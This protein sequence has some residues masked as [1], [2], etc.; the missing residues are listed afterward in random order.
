MELEMPFT[1]FPQ[2]FAA[3]LSVRGMPLLQAQPGQIFWVNN[4][5]VLNPQQKAGSNGNRGTFLDPFSTLTFALTQCV[6]G[7]GDIVMVGAGHYETI[8]DATTLVMAT[9]GV[10]VIGVGSGSSRPTFVFTTATTANVTVLAAN[11]SI[12]N[13]LFMCNFAA[14]ASVF[15]VVSASV[16]AVIAATTMTVAT[17][18][19]GTLYPG[20]SV[21]GTGIIPGTIILSQVSGTTGGAGVYTVSISQTFASGTIT[22]GAKDFAIDSCEF[23]DLSSALNFVAIVTGTT[24]ANAADG[25]TFT[26]NRIASLGTTAATTAIKVLSATYGATVTDNFGVWAVLNDTACMV[27]TGANNMLSFEFARNRLEKPNTSSTGGSFISTSGTA[28]TGHAYDNYMYQLDNSAGIWIATLTGGAF[29]FSNN[30]SPIT[31]AVDKSALINPAA[32]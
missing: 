4:S 32:V 25:L 6:Q 29:G 23:R 26:N 1:N 8:A 31:G 18:G 24:T 27:A 2:G 28:W 30:F 5:T 20:A 21:M 12:Q 16:T 13:C 14:V 7:R 17:V 10:A 19:S 3:G 15:T 22:T 9:A 11:M